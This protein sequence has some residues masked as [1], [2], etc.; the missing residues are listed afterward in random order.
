MHHHITSPKKQQQTN[1]QTNLTTQTWSN[2]VL[3]P[4]LRKVKRKEQNGGDL[5]YTA[6]QQLM[7]VLRRGVMDDAATRWAPTTIGL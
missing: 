3:S 4:N 5:T 6:V 2:Y 1:K 7:E